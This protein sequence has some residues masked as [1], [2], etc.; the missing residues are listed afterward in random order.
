ME[1]IKMNIIEVTKI[2]KEEILQLQKIG[3]QTF[4]ETFFENNTEENMKSYLEND[5]SI[6]KIAAELNNETSEFYFAK[7]DN[8]VIGYLKLNFGQS[9]T[10][11]KD[12]KA[13][14]IERIYVLKEFHGKK[15]G[16]VLYDK[17]IEIAKVK[18]AN[19]VWLGVW[20]ENSRAIN[21]YKKN[22]FVAFDKHIFKLGDDEQTDIMMKKYLSSINIQPL[23]E[24]EGILLSPL[25]ENDFDILYL[26]AS[27][28]K[29]WEQHPNKERWQKEVF[30]TFFF[31]AILSKG[32]FKIIDKSSDSVIGTTRFYDY[33]ESE[34]SIQIGYTFFTTQYWGKGVNNAVKKLMLDYIFNFVSKVHFHIGENN[35]RSQKAISRLGAL[36]TGEQEVTY[37]GE[38]PML[39]FV[40]EITN[41]NWKKQKGNS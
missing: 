39:N 35:I 11:L 15:V 24:S 4:Y 13:I 26:A 37:F 40:Y 41:E 25:Q 38:K 12:D 29:I 9:Q 21:F 17:A 1:T 27:D 10:E 8:E 5:F 33:T 22:G 18:K 16:Q 19:Y 34:N 2:G 3:R 6:D 30:K 14:E 7:L 28:P 36:K 32:A 23:L 20:E 31:G